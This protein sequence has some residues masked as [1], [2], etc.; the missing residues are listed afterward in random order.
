MISRCLYAGMLMF[1]SVLVSAQELREQKMFS[2]SALGF[3]YGYYSMTNLPPVGGNLAVAGYAD[4]FL[5]RIATLNIRAD[6]VSSGGTYLTDWYALNTTTIH[7]QEAYSW[8]SAT[9]DGV[10]LQRVSEFGSVGIGVGADWISYRRYSVS[11]EEKS[12]DPVTHEVLTRNLTYN[13]E[14]VRVSPSVSAVANS[15]WNMKGGV[16][17]MMQVFYKLT[18]PGNGVG[19]GPLKSLNAIGMSF[20][21]KYELAK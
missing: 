4:L 11:A 7:A 19:S 2:V 5:S 3:G 16:R 13:I 12:F 9:L 17:V 18:F 8:R 14:W 15:D 20:A 10:V 6:Y 1:T 21:V